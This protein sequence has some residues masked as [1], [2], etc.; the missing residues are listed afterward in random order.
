MFKVFDTV[1]KEFVDGRY[2]LNTIGLI[3]TFKEIKDY[4]RD[5]IEITTE[6]NR[7]IPVYSTGLKDKDGKEYEDGSIFKEKVRLFQIFWDSSK[8]AFSARSIS[9]PVVEVPLSCLILGKSEIIGSK[10]TNPELLEQ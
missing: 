1:K 2:F 10:Y 6:S 9:K 5:G 8:A 7:Y 4:Y 3:T